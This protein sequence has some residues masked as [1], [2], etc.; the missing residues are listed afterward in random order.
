LSEEEFEFLKLKRLDF[1]KR[2]G[3]FGEKPPKGRKVRKKARLRRATNE[4]L[5]TGRGKHTHCYEP[6]NIQATRDSLYWSWRRVSEY[7]RDFLD[8]E[9]GKRKEVV[10]IDSGL[11]KK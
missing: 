2:A 7:Y 6:T 9:D 4:D 3:Y 5:K 1:L 10:R 11:R 8:E